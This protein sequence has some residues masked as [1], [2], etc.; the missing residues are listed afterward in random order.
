MP[1][2][3][4]S[5]LRFLFTAALLIS[6]SGK[7]IAIQLVPCSQA[8]GTVGKIPLLR[9]CDPAALDV[10]YRHT[11]LRITQ[12][13]KTLVGNAYCT[14]CTYCKGIIRGLF[15][16]SAGKTPTIALVALVA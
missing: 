10:H 9:G 4:L 7:A 16:F 6:V 1:V 8:N 13:S 14:Y 11:G 2:L 12:I 3:S 5:R 15:F